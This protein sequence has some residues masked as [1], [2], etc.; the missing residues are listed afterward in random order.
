[1]CPNGID[2]IKF[3][4]ARDVPRPEPV[5]DARVV[6]GTVCVLRPEKGLPVLL[7]AFARVRA[8]RT[9]LTLV[10]E[11]SGP[12]KDE[13]EASAARLGVAADVVFQ[14]ATTEVPRWLNAMDIFV[15][16]SRSEAMSNALMEAMACGASA[17]ASNVGGNPELIRDGETGLLFPSE[18]AEALASRLQRLVDDPELRSRLAARGCAFIHSEM[19]IERA[20]ARMATIYRELLERRPGSDPRQ[21]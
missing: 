17:V 19:T 11:G 5:R 18:D 15:L 3:A 14:P 2:P 10:F 16:P 21:R 1:V 4:P 13:L 8:Q 9:G 20:S 12:M 7:E 6:I